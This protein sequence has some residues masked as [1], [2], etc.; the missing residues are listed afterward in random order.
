NPHLAMFCLTE[1]ERNP[2]AFHEI[3]DFRIANRVI[4]KQLAELEAAGEVR[5]M[6]L[7][8]FIAALVGMTIYPFLTR[9]GIMH[10]SNMS[11]ENYLIFLEE[12]KRVI[13][14]MIIGYLW[15]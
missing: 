3:V 15:Q 2:E 8:S 5:P 1:S 9:N 11:K 14:A 10:N 12:Q 6:S 4:T 13:P 7:Q